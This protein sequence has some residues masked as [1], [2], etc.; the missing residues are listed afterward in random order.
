MINRLFLLGICVLASLSVFAEGLVRNHPEEEQHFISGSLSKMERLLMSSLK[1]SS[2]KS[3]PTTDD[4]RRLGHFSWSSCGGTSDAF[5]IANLTLSPDPIKLGNPIKITASGQITLELGSPIE[6]DVQVQK[7][8][9]VWVSLPCVDDLGSCNYPDVCARLPPPPCP[10]PL[11]EANLPC[12]CPI[13]TGTYA[14]KDLEVEFDTRKFPGWLTEGDF[15]AH[16]EMKKGG[17]SFAC[18]DVELNIIS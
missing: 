12:T 7:K 9:F 6:V 18:Y 14:V 11:I 10:Q 5:H 8:V 15:K 17:Q 1:A 3:K 13:P 4:R 2:E 16:I